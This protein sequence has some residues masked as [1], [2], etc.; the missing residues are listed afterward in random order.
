MIENEVRS[1]AVGL[2]GFV[3]GVIV[4]AKDPGAFDAG[5]AVFIALASAS[6]YAVG[7]WMRTH[8]RR[9][10]ELARRIESD[11]R[12]AVAD[13]RTRIAREFH[14]AVGHSVTVMVVQAGAARMLVDGDPPGARSRTHASTPARAASTSACGIRRA[15][16]SSRSRTTATHRSRTAGTPAPAA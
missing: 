3:L 6:P 14:D 13:E 10:R 12:T 7:V 15:R 16:S 5:D 2:V 4:V 8:D 11:A 1:I 9:E